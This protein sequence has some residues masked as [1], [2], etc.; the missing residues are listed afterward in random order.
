MMYGDLDPDRTVFWSYGGRVVHLR[1]RCC[2]IEEN[3]RR[4]SAHA[5][6]APDRPLCQWCTGTAPKTGEPSRTVTAAM[7]E[8]LGPEDVGLSPVG[9]R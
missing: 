9:D 6:E 8:R 4:R 1:P 5:R 3:E 7:L 2:Q